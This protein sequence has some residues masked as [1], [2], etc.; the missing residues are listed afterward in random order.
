MRQLNNFKQANTINANQADKSNL[1]PFN[2]TTTSNTDWIPL[3]KLHYLAWTKSL[4]LC[5]FLFRC[6]LI[7]FPFIVRRRSTS[8][9][10]SRIA[11]QRKRRKKTSKALNVNQC[12]YYTWF[13]YC[14]NFFTISRMCTFRWCFGTV[15]NPVSAHSANILNEEI[16]INSSDWNYNF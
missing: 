16:K 6:R 4:N 3:I 8:S 14:L 9:T 5:P 1:Q 11:M 12:N 15:L 10:K 13:I 7:L 2:S